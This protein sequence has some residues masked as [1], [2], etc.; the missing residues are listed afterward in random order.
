M[1]ANLA[2]SPTVPRGGKRYYRFYTPGGVPENVF[3]K[4]SYDFPLLHLRLVGLGVDRGDLQNHSYHGGYY[5]GS[6]SP[7]GENPFA[8]LREEMGFSA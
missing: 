2:D 5:Q 1:G 4:A 8:I 7:D 3:L 6:F